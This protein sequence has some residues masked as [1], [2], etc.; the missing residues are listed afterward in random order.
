MI[1]FADVISIEIFGITESDTLFKIPSGYDDLPG[2][3]QELAEINDSWDL[4]E[5]QFE[6]ANATDDEAVAILLR[7]G[8]DFR[9]ERGQPLRCTK[10]FSRQAEAAAKGIMGKMPD[11][12]GAD[13]ES[14]TTKMMQ[15]AREHMS[16]KR[17]A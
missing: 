13:L 8:L 17:S 9:D 4:H 3:S 6:T 16:K 10:L 7:L 2:W 5:E 15:A 12:E 11:R 1:D 14:W